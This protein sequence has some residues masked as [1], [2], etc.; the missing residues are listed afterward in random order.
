MVSD[1]PYADFDLTFEV[2][3]D[4]ALNSGVQI[5]STATPDAT[6]RDARVSGPQIE[7]DPGNRAWT[8]GLYDEA[9][10]GW[11]APLSANPAAR[12]A[13]RPGDWNRVRVV[14]RG[15]VI[16]TYLNEVPAARSFDAARL[17]GL[18][19]LQVHS[20]GSEKRPLEVR[21]RNLRVREWTGS[22]TAS[23]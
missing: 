14:A 12:R 11:L 4:P 9:G 2:K 16:L 1:K 7:L 5:R 18:I 17:S 19:G 13:F 15:P 23:H 21:W 6:T 22:P 10:R 3:L 20:V 8:A